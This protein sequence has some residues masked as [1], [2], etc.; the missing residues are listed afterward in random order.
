MRGIHPGQW[1]NSQR[2]L[3]LLTWLSQYRENKSNPVSFE[4]ERETVFSLFRAMFGNEIQSLEANGHA[5][6]WKLNLVAQKIAP[7]VI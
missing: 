1:E 2:N 5:C 6:L 7:G 4:I 3:T